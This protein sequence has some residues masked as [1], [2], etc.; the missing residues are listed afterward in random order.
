V[1]VGIPKEIK[2]HEGHVAAGP[3]GAAALSTL[4]AG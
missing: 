3:V 1:N 4:I 2:D